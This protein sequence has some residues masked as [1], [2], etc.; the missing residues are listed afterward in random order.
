MMSVAGVEPVIVLTE[1][2][3]CFDRT[4]AEAKRTIFKHVSRTNTRIDYHLHSIL[5]QQSSRWTNAQIWLQHEESCLPED[6]VAL[7]YAVRG[8]LCLSALEL[9][10][11]QLTILSAPQT[12]VIPTCL[13][14]GCDM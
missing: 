7:M 6:A 13:I 10:L 1:L 8:A 12:L 3:A 4:V 14:E 2:L 11:P 5:G 9:G